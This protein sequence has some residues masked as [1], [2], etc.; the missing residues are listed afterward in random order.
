MTQDPIHIPDGV[1]PI[2]HKTGG[3]GVLETAGVRRLTPRECE[4]LQGF[5]PDWT[6]ID[7]RGKP[8]PDSRRYAALG[9]AVTV[10]VARWLGERLAQAVSVEV[11]A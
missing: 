9:D 2:G 5:P 1:P 6:L 11:A 10:P 4:A 3:Q 7:W 8:A